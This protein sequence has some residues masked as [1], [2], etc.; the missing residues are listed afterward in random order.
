MIQ[1]PDEIRLHVDGFYKMLF[2][3]RPR[4][5]TALADSIW[6]GQQRVSLE[7]NNALLAPFEEDEAAAIIEAM[8]P[9][10]APGPDG[11]PVRFFQVFWPTIKDDILALF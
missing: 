7:E 4:G 5:A 6:V 11:V 1:D 10:S 3:E 2:A 9:S 8:N